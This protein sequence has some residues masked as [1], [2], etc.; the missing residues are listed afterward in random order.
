MPDRRGYGPVGEVFDVVE[1]Q[2]QRVAGLAIDLVIG[3]LPV[4]RVRDGDDGVWQHDAANASDLAL[5]A[6]P[7]HR[8]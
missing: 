8:A 6:C 2:G 7:D 3:M 4:F 1:N 5:R